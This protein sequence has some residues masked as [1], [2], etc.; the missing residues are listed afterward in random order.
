MRTL[1]YSRSRARRRCLSMNIPLIT[2]IAAAILAFSWPAAA[3]VTAPA[4]TGSAPTATLTDT[5]VPDGIVFY[6]GRPFMIRNGRAWLID[7]TLVP[8]GQILTHGGRLVPLPMN[9]GGFAQSTPPAMQPAPQGQ[10]ALQGQPVQQGQ[11]GASPNQPPIAPGI[12]IVSPQGPGT[13]PGTATGNPNVQFG[14]TGAGATGAPGIVDP[15][16]PGAGATTVGPNTRTTGGGNTGATTKP[17]VGGTTT[18]GG[19]SGGGTKR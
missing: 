8:Q 19:N 13:N 12:I 4:S 10:P 14:K 2:S 18:N 11:T 7:A 15:T 1:S 6:N 5:G 17:A 16:N 3:Q 9:Y